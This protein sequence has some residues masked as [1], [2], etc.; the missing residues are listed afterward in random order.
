MTD[1][2]KSDFILDFTQ[3]ALPLQQNLKNNEDSHY[4][5]QWLYWFFHC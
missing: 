3:F 4:W 2:N 5:S 1:E